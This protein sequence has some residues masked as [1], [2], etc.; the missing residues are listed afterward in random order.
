MFDDDFE[1]FEANEEV[2]EE[3]P[4]IMI[5]EFEEWGHK[6]EY[7]YVKLNN[8][9]QRWSRFNEKKSK[10]ISSVDSFSAENIKI[11]TS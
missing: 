1:D 4:E 6:K 9:W 5:V 7:L 11:Y 3:D 2:R 8:Y 10:K